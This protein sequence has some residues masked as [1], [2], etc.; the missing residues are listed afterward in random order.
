MKILF[1]IDFGGDKKMLQR[2]FKDWEKEIKSAK[3]LESIRWGKTAKD[4]KLEFT[5]LGY[6]EYQDLL[7]AEE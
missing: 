3:S 4:N 5:I 1:S 2:M 6:Q 7:T